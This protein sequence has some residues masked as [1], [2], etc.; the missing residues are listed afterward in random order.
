METGSLQINSATARGPD[1]FPFEGASAAFAYTE[2]PV[3]FQCH[4]ILSLAHGIRHDNVVRVSIGGRDHFDIFFFNS[5]ISL[6]T[7]KVQLDER[8]FDV[9]SQ[10]YLCTMEN[11]SFA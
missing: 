9:F 3:L 6:A 2:A 8:I 11:R 5:H 10:E 4:T 7:V 1:H